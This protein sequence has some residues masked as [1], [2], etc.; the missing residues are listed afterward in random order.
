MYRILG[1]AKLRYLQALIICIVFFISIILAYLVS[2]NSYGINTPLL[3]IALF[4]L[5]G[6]L[7]IIIKNSA[8]GVI[9]LIPISL[10]IPFSIGT[11]SE[12]SINSAIIMLVFLIGVW[13]LD[14]IFSKGNVRL[15]QSRVIL[16]CVIF[17]ISSLISFGFGQIPWFN[18]EAAPM[19]AQVGGLFLYLSSIAALLLVAH[20]IKR[21]R[22]LE[23]MT[24][25]FLIFGT[26]LLITNY[27]PFINSYFFSF[28]PSGATGALF[29][30]WIPTLAFSQALINKK[31]GMIWR[32]LLCLLTI[33]TF[34]IGLGQNISW[35]SGYLPGLAAIFS[36]FLL[37]EKKSRFLFLIIFIIVLVFE[38]QNFYN[39]VML[40]DNPYS[41]TTRLAAWQILGKIILMNPVLGVGFANYYWYTPIFPIMGYSVVFN[42]HNNYVDIIAQTG[43]L[44]L[45][46]FLWI[47]FELG[48]LG[49]NLRERAAEGFTKAYVYGV[50]GGLTGTL[51]SGMLGDWFLPFVYNIGFNG[52]RATILSWLFFGGLI[53]IDQII[54]HNDK[55]HEDLIAR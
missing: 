1:K 42:S 10:A 37:Y 13:L 40:G 33:G 14:L 26:L 17:I 18:V 36:I 24:W 47:S 54:K 44:G 12:S 9:L 48:R 3:V 27:L 4:L 30:V 43:L 49:L 2:R 7:L 28:F 38:S 52:F 39:L 11:G 20:R 6:P 41:L 31:L 25:L 45:A 23:W 19:R 34:Y 21:I 29:W 53:S 50:I 5:I 8:L 22:E 51:I 55:V 15:I 32:L 35:I 46:C 16:S